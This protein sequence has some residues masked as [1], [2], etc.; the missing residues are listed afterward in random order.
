VFVDVD[1]LTFNT[2]VSE[3]WQRLTPRV[4]AVMTVHVL[5]NST[6]MVELQEFVREHDLVLVED[7]YEAL[8]SFYYPA[9]AVDG[10]HSERR[11]LGTCGDFGTYSFY[12]SHHITCGEG[13]MVVCQTEDD[14]NL[15]R[16]LRAHGW[17][18]H[19]TNR[20]AVEAEHAS[21][22]PR[23]LF[24]NVGFNV[25]PMEVQAAMLNVQLPKL[26]EFNACRRSNLKRFQRTL[27][28]DARAKGC[29]ALMQATPGT[30]PAW[31]GISAVLH[32]EYGHQLRHFLDY[33]NH[34]GVENR[35]IIGGNFVRQP[36]IRTFCHGV[37]DPGEFLGAEL[38]HTRGFFIGVHHLQ[39]AD[40][41]LGNLVHIILD[42]PFRPQPGAGTA[43]EP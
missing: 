27:D 41:M 21:V 40:E 24:I 23:F 3:L 42:F 28:R 33:L 22:D 30:D 25:R 15:L 35:P 34:N 39:T 38:L 9:A 13:G 6:N 12:F 5:G 11:F 31:F 37:E 43:E 1:P 2:P 19:L 26:G 20:A 32:A 14:F 17:T 18:R 16:C 4:K 8:G 10:Q 7:T 29:L 36:C